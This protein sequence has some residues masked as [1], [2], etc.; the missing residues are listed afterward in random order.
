MVSTPEL[1]EGKKCEMD[2]EKYL[3]W[4]WESRQTAGIKHH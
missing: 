2:A 3:N 4:P 1:D